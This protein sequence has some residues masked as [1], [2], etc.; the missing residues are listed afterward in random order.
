MV[1]VDDVPVEFHDLLGHDD[2]RSHHAFVLVFE[3][4]AVEHVPPVR[5]SELSRDMPASPVMTFKL[6]IALAWSWYH[7]AVAR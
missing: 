2:E 6:V 7:S 4:V 3:N 5:P 1:A